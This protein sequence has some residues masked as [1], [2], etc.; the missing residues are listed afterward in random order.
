MV[1]S[2][3]KY[4]EFS[5]KVHGYVSIMCNAK[6]N[7]VVSRVHTRLGYKYS[8]TLAGGEDVRPLVLREAKFCH[9]FVLFSPLKYLG[10]VWRYI[11]FMI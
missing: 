9:K 10:Q 5:T 6:W 3:E 4:E 11:T 7:S 2:G 1:Y 8:F